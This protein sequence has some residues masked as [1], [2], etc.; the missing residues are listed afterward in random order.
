MDAI[1]TGSVAVTAKGHRCGKGEGYSDIEYGILRE[2]GHSPVPVATTV[3]HIQL[4]MDF[5]REATDLPLLYIVTPEKIVQVRPRLKPPTGIN[6]EKL[7]PKAL[8]DMPI[9][10]DLRDKKNLK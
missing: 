3:H 5:P 6:W 1:V 4:L 8:E 10:Q 2:L 7:P 9:L